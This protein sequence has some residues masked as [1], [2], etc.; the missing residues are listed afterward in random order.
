M[1]SW[2]AELLVDP[3]TGGDL[4]VETARTD[5]SGEV[6][7]GRLVGVGDVGYVVRDGIPRFVGADGPDGQDGQVAASF[8]Y[9][10]SM[11]SSYEAPGFAAWYATGC[12][13]S[14]ASPTRP[15]YGSISRAFNACSR[16]VVA[17]E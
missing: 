13:R 5:A 14:T 3:A 10:W 16:L 11:R 1:H 6:L 2:L 17:A 8:G 15:V 9:K 7:D 12:W 4:R